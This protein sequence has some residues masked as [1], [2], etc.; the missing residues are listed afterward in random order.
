MS[1][2]PAINLAVQKCAGKE[3]SLTYESIRLI[4]LL[5]SADE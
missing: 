2:E 1:I 5:P 3:S 4:L